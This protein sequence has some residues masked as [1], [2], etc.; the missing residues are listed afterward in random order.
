MKVLCIRLLLLMFGIGLIFT[1][2]VAAQETQQ[3][4]RISGVVVDNDN[5]TPLTDVTIK[6]VDTN[7]KAK[8]DET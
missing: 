5:D 4:V 7:I 1:V 2:G 8:T 3:T 6:V